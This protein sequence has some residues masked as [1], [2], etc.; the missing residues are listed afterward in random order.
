[1]KRFL[2]FL[3]T[4]KYGYY[5]S[6]PFSNRRYFVRIRHL[7]MRRKSS[8]LPPVHPYL[9]HSTTTWTKFYPSLTLS[10]P[11]VDILHTTIYSLSRDTLWT[12]YWP[13]SS[14]QRNYWMSPFHLPTIQSINSHFAISWGFLGERPLSSAQWG[15]IFFEKAYL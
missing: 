5:S 6:I 12:F 13:P 11:R 1:M 3:K 14:C 8:F 15:E 4:K 9:G 10:P 7:F 2:V